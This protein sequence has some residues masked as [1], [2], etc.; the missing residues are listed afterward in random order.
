MV[1]GGQEKG[2]GGAL[3]GDMESVVLPDGVRG[4]RFDIR[5]RPVSEDRGCDVVAARFRYGAPRDAAPLGPS[6]AIP[7]EAQRLPRSADTHGTRAAGGLPG[8]VFLPGSLL[9]G[10]I[11]PR[12]RSATAQHPVDHLPVIT[13]WTTASVQPRQ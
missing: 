6:P 5:D 13:P 1:N 9:L 12:S 2:V 4:E 8:S 11:A 3:R 7:A 10:Q